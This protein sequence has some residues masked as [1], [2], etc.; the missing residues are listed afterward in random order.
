LEVAEES[1]EELIQLISP[2]E[3]K[4]EDE[5]EYPKETSFLYS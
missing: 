3:E 5:K 2:E 1:A 4:E